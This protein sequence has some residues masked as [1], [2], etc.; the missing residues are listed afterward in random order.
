MYFKKTPDILKPIANDLVWDIK[1]DEDVIF[2]TFDDGPVPRVTPKVLDILDEYGAK[3]TFFCVGENIEKYP[4]IFQDII[5]RGHA[6]GNHTYSHENGWKTSQYNYLKSYLKCRELSGSDIFRPPFGRISRQQ[7]KA[8]KRQS[9][10]VMW[11]VLSG[12]FDPDCSKEQCLDN[13]MSHSES[14]SIVVF[15]DSIKAKDRLLYALPK[16][17]ELKKEFKFVKLQFD[18]PEE[19][20]NK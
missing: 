9:T 4:H 2:L 15:H 5:D 8:I 20:E 12:D 17:L 11:D 7:V 19:E 1:T 14:G 13:V 16:M 18:S 10:I 3:A 6:V